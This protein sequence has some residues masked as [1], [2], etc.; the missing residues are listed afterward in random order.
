MKSLAG[1][2]L[3]PSIIVGLAAIQSFGIDA[4]RALHLYQTPDSL[5]SVT[6]DTISANADT[7][8]ARQD[9]VT[10]ADT[11]IAPRD[12]IVVPDSLKDTDPLKF[13]Y[14]I[15]I[16]IFHKSSLPFIIPSSL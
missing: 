2:I 16:L 10:V 12:T 5:I 7:T 3:V 8:I 11:T 6:A 4:G 9:S 1:K 14:F 15:A 13:K